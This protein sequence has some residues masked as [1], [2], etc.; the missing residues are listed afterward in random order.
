M[1]PVAG[2]LAVCLA[3]AAAPASA[4]PESEALRARAANEMFNLDRDQAL[5]SFRKAVAADPE[6]PAAH[7]GLAT[8]LWLGI[9]FHHGSMTVDD[10]L[11]RPAV[12]G[13]PPMPVAPEVA[14]AFNENVD[15]ALAIARTRLQRNPRDVDAHYQLGAAVGLRAS[16]VAT[17]DGKVFGAFRAAR[18]AY[19]EHEKVLELD[20]R[21]QDAGLIVGTYRYI[22]A[23]LSLPVRWMAYVVG[24]GGDKARGLRMI[25]GAAAYG[26]DN[27]VDA[28]FALILLYN[29]ERRYDE[30]LKQL[31][32]LRDQFPRNHLVWLEMG[33]T[34]LRA[35]RSAEAEKVLNEGFER[36]V[37]DPRER[38]FGERALWYYKRG[39]ARAALNKTAE[40]TADL[41]AALGVDGRKWV[42]G[43]SHFELGKL[44]L[45]SGDR[46]R[47]TSE[48]GL[49]ATLC[50][51]DN[52]PTTADEARRLMH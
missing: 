48:L 18:E 34:N 20:P 23:A 37:N 10:Y 25:E 43:R 16:Y 46:V 32:V 35:G 12:S 36:F 49:A 51:S 5:D 17:V 19:E 39:A 26:G 38:M 15:R 4:S 7:R 44:A 29:R 22:V 41:N 8:A 31:G 28:R 47:A 45:R 14:A 21:R 9:T 3:A 50:E 40:A 27:Q 2:V 52:D 24:F 13:N 11:G 30:A 42:Q 33:S 1:R 6:D